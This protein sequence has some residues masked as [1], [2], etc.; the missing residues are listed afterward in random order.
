MNSSICHLHLLSPRLP[1]SLTFHDRSKATS[2]CQHPVHKEAVI[3]NPWTPDPRRGQ[4][5]VFHYCIPGRT[6]EGVTGRP[7]RWSRLPRTAWL[8]LAPH[9]TLAS[10]HLSSFLALSFLQESWPQ[11]STNR[12]STS[13][14][15]TSSALSLSGARTPP[16]PCH[17]PSLLMKSILLAQRF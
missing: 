14:Q 1:S 3:S 6:L 7:P 5:L 13:S 2:H 12:P 16:C 9:P 11:I 17:S 10:H 4:D 15:A 8:L